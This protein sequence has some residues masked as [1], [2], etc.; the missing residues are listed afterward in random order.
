MDLLPTRDGNSATAPKV[1]FLGHTELAS[2]LDLE[3]LS[4]KILCTHFQTNGVWQT[5]DAVQQALRHLWQ[6]HEAQHSTSEQIV[7]WLNELKQRAEALALPLPSGGQP[8]IHREHL[9]KAFQAVVYHYI[10]EVK[11]AKRLV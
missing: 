8:L 4:C 6:G 7:D 1:Y 11:V 3:A 2:V 9:K 5:N 10:A